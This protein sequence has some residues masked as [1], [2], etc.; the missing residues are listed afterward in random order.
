MGLPL[1]GSTFSVYGVYLRP[2]PVN[3]S[4]KDSSGSVHFFRT[5][6]WCHS[7]KKM[8]YIF[9]SMGLSHASNLHTGYTVT[10]SPGCLSTHRWRCCSV[11]LPVAPAQAKI[12]GEPFPCTFDIG[13]F[14]SYPGIVAVD[15]DG[16]AYF[17]TSYVFNEYGTRGDEVMLSFQKAVTFSGSLLVI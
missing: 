1:T 14:N 13:Y 4:H 7:V 6:R 11:P 17:P 12:S 16:A 8:A 2:V 15:T 5:I 9:A 3:G 10:C